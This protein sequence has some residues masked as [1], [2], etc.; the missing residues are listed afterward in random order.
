MKLEILEYLPELSSSQSSLLFIHGGSHGAWCWKEN[1]LPYFSSKG[2]PSYALSLRGHGESEG[3]ESIHFFSLNDYMNDVLEVISQLSEKP[4]LIGHSLG[5]ALV[6]KI[7]CL[8]PEKI[9]AAVL[10][11]TTPP[12]GMFRDFRRLLISRYKDI[13]Q[14]RLFDKGKSRHMPPQVFFSPDLPAEKRDE[15]LGLL[16]PESTKAQRE[17]M[18]RIVPRSV[19]VKVPLLILGS[20]QDW[21]FPGKTVATIGEKY[22]TEPVIFNN[23]CHDMMLDPNW[24]TVA[25]QILPFLQKLAP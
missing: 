2:F 24:R 14:I 5:G 10:M 25:D 16:Q 18:R 13:Y 23:I 17:L 15:Y 3:N 9:Q 7:L 19:S 12:D 8:Y 20:T 6:Q 1:F 22:K 11:S 4:V 21:F